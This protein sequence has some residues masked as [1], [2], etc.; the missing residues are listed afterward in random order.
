MLFVSTVLEKTLS[1][2]VHHHCLHHCVLWVPKWVLSLVL[3]HKYD[4]LL[5]FLF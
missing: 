3:C 1:F 5:A 2:D 4:F